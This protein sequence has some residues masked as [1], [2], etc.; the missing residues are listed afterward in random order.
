MI[1][2]V[3]SLTTKEIHGRFTAKLPCHQFHV[4]PDGR[5]SKLSI[6]NMLEATFLVTPNQCNVLF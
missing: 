2:H 1:Q 5:E 3:F 6:G 4:A